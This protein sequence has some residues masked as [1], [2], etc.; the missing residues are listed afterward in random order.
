MPAHAVPGE[1]WG[2]PLRAALDLP[3]EGRR[4]LTAP[5]EAQQPQLRPRGHWDAEVGGR[6]EGRTV[7]MG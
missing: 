3:L 5:V 4:G 7:M 1:S 6:G 2:V